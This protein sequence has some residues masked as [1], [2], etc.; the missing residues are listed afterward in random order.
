[1]DGIEQE[2]NAREIVLPSELFLESSK[3]KPEPS[4]KMAA[5]PMSLQCSVQTKFNM[6][7]NGRGKTT[8]GPTYFRFLLRQ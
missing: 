3:N 5:P 1:M 6:M 2:P 4:R 7:A 8:K